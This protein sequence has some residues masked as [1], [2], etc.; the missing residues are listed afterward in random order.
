[1]SIFFR[2]FDFALTRP[3]VPATLFGLWLA[4]LHQVSNNPAQAMPRMLVPQQD[5]ILHFVFFLGGAVVLAASLRLLAKLHGMTL[6]LTAT[7]VMG[8]LG[9]LDEY[10]QQFIPGRS[11]LSLPDWIA[12][13]SGAVAGVGVL[14][15]LINRLQRDGNKP[16]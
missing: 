3:A 14:R 10:N 15:L 4:I 6:F 9:A 2:I 12:D 1:M 13:V 11:G 16:G 8:L 5:K 7:V